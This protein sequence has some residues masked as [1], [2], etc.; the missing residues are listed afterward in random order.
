L[1]IAGIYIQYYHD[2]LCIGTGKINRFVGQIT[3]SNWPI[4]RWLHAVLAM[5][6]PTGMPTWNYVCRT[7]VGIV[8]PESVG[9]P[10]NC[11]FRTTG[12]GYWR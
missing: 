11:R 9:R 2:Y 1:P 10:I 12:L 7:S 3:T 8:I 6:V 5:A 4:S